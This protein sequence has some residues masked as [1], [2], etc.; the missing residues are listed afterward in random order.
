MS[1]VAVVPAA[2]KRRKLAVVASVKRSL[3]LAI[4]QKSKRK[5]DIKIPIPR[6]FLFSL[7]FWYSLSY[8]DSPNS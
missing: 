5:N 7:R 3:N 2:L 1:A 4:A 6:G 8:Y